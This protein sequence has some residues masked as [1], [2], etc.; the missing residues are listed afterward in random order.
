MADR[1]AIQK[2]ADTL[3]AVLT[4]FCDASPDGDTEWIR[5]LASL[6]SDV[7]DLLDSLSPLHRMDFADVC[8]ETL[9]LFRENGPHPAFAKRQTA[10]VSALGSN[11]AARSLVGNLLAM[12]DQAPRA[13]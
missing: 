5:P 9:E 7:Y 4:A 6:R 13:S 2:L 3:D 12:C 1:A 11:A 10:M 8:R